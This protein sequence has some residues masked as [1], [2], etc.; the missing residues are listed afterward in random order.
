MLKI[1]E[2]LFFVKT[3]KLNKCNF[4]KYLGIKRKTYM[5]T[6]V[7]RLFDYHFANA[8][9]L[10]KEYRKY[11]RKEFTT[12]DSFLAQRHN[13]FPAEIED[14]A[15]KRIFYKDLSITSD[16]NIVELMN[17][18]IISKAFWAFEEGCL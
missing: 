2:K 18:E 11:Y 3:A 14:F 9:S 13:L 5:N 6:V 7:I 1:D 16:L 12:F 8:I 4:R 17:D 15:Q 10:R